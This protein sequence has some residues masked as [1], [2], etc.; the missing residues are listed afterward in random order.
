M[1]P[2]TTSRSLRRQLTFR[3]RDGGGTEGVSPG[4]STDAGGDNPPV[5]RALGERQRTWVE[6]RRRRGVAAV[7]LGSCFELE[8]PGNGGVLTEALE[9]LPR[10]DDRSAR[11]LERGGAGRARVAGAEEDCVSLPTL[12]CRRSK[13][14]GTRSHVR[15]A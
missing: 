8:R 15:V 1:F 13:L 3:L 14:L 9:C 4:Q 11:L 10:R 2:R 7:P 12:G 5:S 6:L